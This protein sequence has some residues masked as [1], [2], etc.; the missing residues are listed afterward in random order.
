MSQKIYDDE[1]E[2]ATDE[3]DVFVL[4][5]CGSS[6]VNERA[7]LLVHGDQLNANEAN[8]SEITSQG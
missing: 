4:V 2:K 7:F 3:G 5:T 6:D 1:H 8:F